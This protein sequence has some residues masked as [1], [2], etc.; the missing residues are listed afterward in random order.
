ML[1]VEVDLLKE[2]DAAARYR[3]QLM[4]TQVFYAADGREI[5]RNAGRMSAEAILDRL[6]VDGTAR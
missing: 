4:P 5:G 3:V 2:R 1:V 6:G